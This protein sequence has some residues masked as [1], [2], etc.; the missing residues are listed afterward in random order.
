VSETCSCSGRTS[1]IVEISVFKDTANNCDRKVITQSG[2]PKSLECTA[3]T[4]RIGLATEQHR[5]LKYEEESEQQYSI[6]R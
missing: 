6:F 3:E 4:T 2:L 1:V 5:T